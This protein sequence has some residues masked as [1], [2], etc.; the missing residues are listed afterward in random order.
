MNKKEFLKKQHNTFHNELLVWT[1]MNITDE[2]L[3]DD[4]VLFFDYP[5]GRYS[6]TLENLKKEAK[7][8]VEKLAIK[9]EKKNASK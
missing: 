9:I 3:E 4:T 6:I 1:S 7:K 8:E 2:K 5:E